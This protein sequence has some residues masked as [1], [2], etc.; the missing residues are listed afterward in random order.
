MDPP[1][2]ASGA[3]L[4]IGC[5]PDRGQIGIDARRREA[6]ARMRAND[7]SA[8][9]PLRILNIVTPPMTLKRLPAAPALVIAAA[10][11][12]SA[13]RDR[14][15]TSYRIPKEADLPATQAAGPAEGPAPSAAPAL[16]WTAPADWKAQPATGMRQA[17]YLVYGAAGAS[18]DISVVSFPGS[19]GDDLANINRWRNQLKLPAVAATDLPG[20]IQ[21]VSNPAGTLVIADISGNTPEK[22]AARILGAWLRQPDRVYFFKMMGPADLVGSQKEAFMAFLQSVNLAARPAGGAPASANT[23]DLPREAPAPP[24]AAPAPAAP[25]AGMNSMPV[26]AESGA[27]LL[28]TTPGTWTSKPASAMRKGSY[29]VEG[30]AEVAITAFPGDVGGILANVNR[31]RGQAGLDP[32]DDSGLGSVTTTFDA[33]GLH[34]VVADASMG[35]R[36][37]VAAIV[38][39]NGG[40]W[41]FK[42]TGPTDAVTRAKPAFIEFIKTVRAP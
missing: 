2:C 1:A 41:F 15:I 30:G 21:Q 24:T 16:Q 38:P 40:T 29:A 8:R 23:N 9:P 12:V 35:S 39:W 17:S 13:C 10:C 5:S 3:G 34:I 31:W 14:D 22:G 27:S 11:I 6:L 19:G 37:I 36:P 25:G 32:V 20:L 33:N 7:G 28:W 42:L 26:Q 4:P 18:A